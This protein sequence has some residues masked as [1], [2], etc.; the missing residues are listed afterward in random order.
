M[1]RRGPKQGP[2]PQL[3]EADPHAMGSQR[4]AHLE[5]MGAMG[6]AVTTINNRRTFTG[7]FQTWCNDR[8]LSRASEITKP[9]LERYRRHLYHYRKKDGAPLTFRHQHHVLS[10]LRSFFA[11]LSKHNHLLYNPASELELPK[12]P[13]RLPRYV[14]SISEAE[15]IINQA[16]INDPVGLRDRAIMETF[17]STGMRRMELGHLKLYDMDTERGTVFI[18]YGKGN[19]D[20]MIPIGERA[21]AWIDKY[22]HE[23]RPELACE[24][25]DGAIFLTL[26]GEAFSGNRLSGLVKHYVDKSGIGKQGACH[27]FRHSMATHMLE[28]GA[29]IR[30]IQV[31]LGHAELSTTE[32]YTKVVIGKLKEVHTRTHP[33]RQ[34]KTQP[35]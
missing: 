21:C 33:A 28:N 8:G 10:H 16:D 1:A 3:R 12:L 13:Q 5:W 6:Y 24:P 25:D 18:R 9:I 11:W 15:Q 22:L 32:I 20:R 2:A 26:S 35:L 34:Q 4:E 19:K 23:V 29:D 14:L 30:F 17:Y 27:L 7:Y 31:M